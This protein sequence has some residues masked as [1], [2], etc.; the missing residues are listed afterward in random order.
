MKVLAGDIGGTKTWLLIAHCQQGDCSPLF[1]QRYHSAAYPS[2]TAMVHEF[3]DAAAAHSALPV[4][5]A[6]FGV[7]GPVSAREAGDS[8]RITNLPWRIEATEL[9]AELGLDRAHLVNDF[10]ATGYGIDALA[11]GD[12]ITLQPGLPVHGAPRV[13]I[14][15]G[16]GLGMGVLCWRDGHYEPLPSEGGHADFAPTDD[17]Q[18][19]LLRHLRA[20]YG[21]VSVERV[22][23]GPG[24]VNILDFL[25]DTGAATVS[26][27]L[28]A[29]ME[30]GD[31]AAAISRC[32]LDGS[33]PAAVRALG[34]FVRAYGA[35]AGDLALTAL[36][37]GGVYIGGGIAPKLLGRLQAGD[38]MEAFRAKG[39]M[40]GLCADMPVHVI[41]NPKVGLLGAAL[42]ASRT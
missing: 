11:P 37:R 12:L 10:Q 19:A 28:D 18:I 7:A 6:C 35:Q 30:S 13:I 22:V 27:A 32:A 8:A 26:A 4:E 23:S 20:R 15:A 1:E 38:F 5:G 3:L 2:L 40:A 25:R 34:L 39:R 36:A 42:K 21:R 17:E 31:A 9:A 29:A 41:A 33:D 14:G 24:L 16:T